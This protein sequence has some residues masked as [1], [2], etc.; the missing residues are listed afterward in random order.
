MAGKAVFLVRLLPRAA[1]RGGAEEAR[2][3]VRER[4][5]EREW[6]KM[7][8]LPYDFLTNPLGAVRQTFEKAVASSPPD[9]DPAAIFRGKDWGAVD[10]FH[11]FLFEKGGLAQVRFWIINL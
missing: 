6:R 5:R 10:L 3:R 1:A 4:E 11:D 8:G 2:D 9:V 7:V